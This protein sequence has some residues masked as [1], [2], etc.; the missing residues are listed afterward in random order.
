MT[1]ESTSVTV[2]LL[3]EGCRRCRLP[4]RACPGAHGCAALASYTLN[5]GAS[6]ITIG[7]WGYVIFTERYTV[8]SL[9]LFY[10]IFLARVLKPHTDTLRAYVLNSLSV[11][12]TR[13]FQIQCPKETCFSSK[14]LALD[15][16]SPLRGPIL[17]PK[18]QTPTSP[19]LK[20]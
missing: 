15:K 17:Q 9:T 16:P 12:H 4:R 20:P 13:P 11:W 1:Q 6:I 3:V 19:K 10:H 7:F 8:L 5:T 2:L 14:F 18:P